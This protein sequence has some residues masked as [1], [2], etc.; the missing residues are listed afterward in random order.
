MLTPQNQEMMEQGI[1]M[2]SLPK[3]IQDTIRITRLLH[4]RF[5]WVDSLCIL[6]GSSSEAQ[7]DWKDQSSQMA[8]I[9]QQA[10]LTIGASTS[11][12]AYDG[13]KHFEKYR[14]FHVRLPTRWSPLVSHNPMY[15]GIDAHWLAF[16]FKPNLHKRAWTHQERLLST[17]YMTFGEHGILWECAHAR[18]ADNAQ[19][20]DYT[21]SQRNLS[22][23]LP[24][25]PTYIDWHH[26]IAD[27]STMKLTRSSDK[28][29]ALS[30]LREHFTQSRSSKDSDIAGLWVENLS[31]D[32]LWQRQ[33]FI[34]DDTPCVKD[35]IA[36]SW[37][38]VSISLP[39]EWY[40]ADQYHEKHTCCPECLSLL[41]A[42][43]ESCS[44]GSQDE[45]RGRVKV[46]AIMK[47]IKAF[48]I[49]RFGLK[50]EDESGNCSE[51]YFDDRAA[52]TSLRKSYVTYISVVGLFCLQFHKIPGSI[53]LIVK[54]TGSWHNE[55]QRIGLYCSDKTE[56][57]TLA[58]F[59][60]TI[61]LV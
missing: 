29:V 19:D 6:Q 18:T 22:P 14:D 44:K 33:L 26:V 56:A 55:F 37:S 17:R 51:A 59:P 57:D 32:L 9:Y 41:E 53:G 21:Y 58:Q 61:T 13:I 49:E 38:W 42:S 30:G 43:T 48:S 34:P 45:I 60:V 5:L 39:I 11:E 28:L 35:C 31:W 50:V 8:A 15:V 24:S 1:D 23:R 4:V 54:P 20:L 46:K 10:T 47:A 40:E 12:G 2:N 36:P 25:T 7:V 16:P 3:T 52:E 27:Y